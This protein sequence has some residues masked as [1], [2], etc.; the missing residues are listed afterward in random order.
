MT[1]SEDIYKTVL[2]N[3]HEGV[4]VVDQDRRITYWNRGAERISG[5]P[6]EMVIGKP[7]SENI[8]I[9]IGD[10]GQP[11]CD[12]D[13]PL[14]DAMRSGQTRFAEVYLHHADGHRVPIFVRV[15]PLFDELGNVVGAAEVFSDNTSM[16]AALNKVN[17][18]EKTVALDALTGVGSRLYTEMQLHST[19]NQLKRYQLPFGVLFLDIDR[20]K[21]VNDVYGHDVGDEV[22]KMVANTLK[23]NVRS[24]DYVG[25]WGGEEFIIILVNIE[26]LHL[27][28]IAEK[29]RLLVGASH[30]TLGQ[31]NI[32]VTVSIG[33]ALAA[34]SDSVESLLKRADRLLYQSKAAGRNRVTA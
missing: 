1:I 20:F 10:D 5:Y 19:L 32:R 7:C 11:L 14:T 21:K 2:D 29:L 27:Y 28:Q 23:H 24:S 18:L 31:T 22:L 13:C 34:T 25:R 8:L 3:L 30:Y 15:T 9:H 12:R 4:Y 17:D 33:G 6:S 26:E 16:V